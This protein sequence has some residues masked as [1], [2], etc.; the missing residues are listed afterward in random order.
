ML[1]QRDPMS[2]YVIV[3]P[4]SAPVGPL[5]ASNITAH[6]ATIQWQ[7]PRQRGSSRVRRY[8]IE[9]SEGGRHSVWALCGYSSSDSRVYQ[10][11]HLTEG[12]QW[13][14]RVYAENDDGRSSP[15]EGSLTTSQGD[16]KASSYSYTSSSLTS[17]FTDRKP[18]YTGSSLATKSG[19]YEQSKFFL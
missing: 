14:V 15:L 17:K 6:S 18:A 5:R 10:L 12:K 7:A 2:C 4:P 3:A 13:L 8:I 19:E 11:A 1:Y 16:I 9:K